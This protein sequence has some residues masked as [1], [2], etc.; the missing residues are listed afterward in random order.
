[1]NDFELTVPNLYMENVLL[2][3]KTIGKFSTNGGDSEPRIWP[4]VNHF[5]HFFSKHRPKYRTP[6]PPEILYPLLRMIQ[7][8][9]TV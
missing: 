8:A 9:R 4:I 3:L 1:M 6:R 7:E 2:V 5:I